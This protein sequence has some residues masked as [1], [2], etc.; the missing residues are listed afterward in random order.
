[1]LNVI[2]VGRLNPHFS[3]L[4]MEVLHQNLNGNVVHAVVVDCPT[5]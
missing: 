4:W 5:R 1:M 3:Q 2:R